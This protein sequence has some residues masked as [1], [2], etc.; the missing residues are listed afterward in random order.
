MPKPVSATVRNQWKEKIIDQSQSG[1]SIAS[2]C[3][4]NNIKVHTF[5]YWRAKCQPKSI[6]RSDFKE[7]QIQQI[8]DTN[9]KK[10][11]ISLQYQEFCIHLDQQFDSAA[12][13]HC[14]QIL[15]ELSC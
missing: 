8:A 7:V 14:L 3:R 4:Q 1:L 11:G 10:S 15:K 9:P 5:I 12:L 2:W 13:K 6:D